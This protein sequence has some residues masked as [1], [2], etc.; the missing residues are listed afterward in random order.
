[1]E[2]AVGFARSL[3][4]SG[5]ASEEEHRRIV[6]LYFL[7]IAHIFMLDKNESPTVGATG[8]DMNAELEKSLLG[9]GVNPVSVKQYMRYVALWYRYRN[10]E[11]G[12]QQGNPSRCASGRS[13]VR[14]T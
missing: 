13:G 4:L 8:V 11:G 14:S 3:K 12:H 7:A 10:G 2:F 6:R 9:I 1:M 5:Y